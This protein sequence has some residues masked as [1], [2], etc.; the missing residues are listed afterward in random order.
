[1][2]SFLSLQSLRFYFSLELCSEAD[3]L[4][5]ILSQTLC[6]LTGTSNNIIFNTI[7]V[8]GSGRSASMHDLLSCELFASK[9]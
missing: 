2:S 1:M 4:E 6:E 7:P 5:L 9:G 3:E 8:L